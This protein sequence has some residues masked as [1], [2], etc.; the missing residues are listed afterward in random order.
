M[1]VRII[2]VAGRPSAWVAEAESLYLRRLPKSWRAAVDRIA[3]SGKRQS[4]QAGDARLDESA[5]ILKRVD[6]ADQMV[7]LDERGRAWRSREFAS[8]LRR[9]LAAGSD[10]SFIVGGA[11]GVDDDCRARAD[12]VLSLSSLTMPHELAR[13]VLLEQLYRASTIIAGH[14]YHRD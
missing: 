12:E 11:D 14:P 9:W 6:R 13:V 5:R 10:L 8:R 7:L 3:P 1:H 4:G 2:A